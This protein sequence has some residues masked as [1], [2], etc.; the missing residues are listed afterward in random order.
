MPLLQRSLEI[1]RAAE[2]EVRVVSVLNML[3]SGLAEMYELERAERYL[4]ECVAFGDAHEVTTWYS[5]SWVALVHVYRGRWDEGAMHALHVLSHGADPITRISCL[6]ALGRIRAR[7][8]DPGASEALDE[9]LELALPGGHLQRLGHV[10]A[11]RAEAAWLAGDSE[12][13]IE[14]AQAAYALALEKRHLWFAGELAYWQ[15]KAGA[16]D[17]A[18]D[19]IAEPYRLQLD[20][21]ATR[22]RRGVARASL[23]VRGR[24]DA[25][26]RGDECRRPGGA[27]PARR[28]G[29]HAAEL[30]AA[31]RPARAARVDAREPGRPDRP[32]AR[33]R[34]CSSRRDSRTAR[35]P[36]GSCSRR[37]PSTITSPRSCASSALARA[38]RPRPATAK[39]R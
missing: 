29:R 24:A 32:R 20:G 21:D 8:G 23:P 6:I 5:Q 35:S 30:R 13:T 10:Y 11:A 1:A 28:R 18:P 27:R 36:S 33:G 31:A 14:E 37:A 26:R 3:G 2:L 19:W 4:H 25:R 9:A 12:R 7:R 16:L 34:S 39:Y 15:W 17:D 22:R 38:A